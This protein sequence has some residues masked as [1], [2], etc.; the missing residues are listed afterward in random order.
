MAQPNAYCIVHRNPQTYGETE[1]FYN[2]LLAFG[3]YIKHKNITLNSPLKLP[4][5][6][7]SWKMAYCD[8]F[9]AKGIHTWCT[10]E[11]GKQISF[12]NW[13]KVTSNLYSVAIHWDSGNVEWIK[14]Y[15]EA[16]KP[17]WV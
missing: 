14:K 1:E 11:N 17:D 6:D 13:G 5:N 3:G 9:L 8:L 2:E 15:G 16:P 4:L 12:S 10:D 7:T